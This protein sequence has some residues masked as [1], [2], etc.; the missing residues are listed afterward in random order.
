MSEQEPSYIW[1]SEQFPFAML[2]ILSLSTMAGQSSGSVCA[3]PQYT[4]AADMEDRKGQAWFGVRVSGVTAEAVDRNLIG[5]FITAALEESKVKLRL[6]RPLFQLV[7]QVVR[8][9]EQRPNSRI[10]DA[11][12]KD[13]I[14]EAYIGN[15]VWLRAAPVISPKLHRYG[16]FI[17]ILHMASATYDAFLYHPGLALQEFV[18]H[19]K[20][21]KEINSELGQL[22]P[23]FSGLERGLV[24]RPRKVSPRHRSSVDN[25]P[26]PKDPR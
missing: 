1:K 14:V 17:G 15:G 24:F 23:Q 16:G 3:L 10:N 22:W 9:I 13:S 8:T 6:R 7:G 19:D 18:D 2:E 5:K 21:A 12:T 20:I 25:L 11:T 4:F 26:E